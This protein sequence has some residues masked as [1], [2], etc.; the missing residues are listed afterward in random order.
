MAPQQGATYDDILRQAR[1][2]ER[3]GFYA[4]VRSEHFLTFSGDG[5]PGP[6]DAWVTLAGLAR[7]TSR[8]RL[9]TM[10]SPATF[11]LPGPL[12]VA[13]AQVDAMSGGRVSLGLGAGWADQE[14]LAYGLPFP[15][16]A[17]RFD[18]LDEQLS[19]IRGLWTTPIG[20]PFDFRGTHYELSG[21]PGLPKPVQRPH[22]PIVVG[23]SGR[24]RTPAVAARHAD[25]FNF[26]SPLPS[27]P[28]LHEAF[29]R[30]D[31][32]CEDRGRDPTTLKRSLT[33]TVVCGDDDA[34]LRRRLEAPGGAFFDIAGTPRR[35][36][37][38]IGEFRS[39]E[40]ERVYLRVNDLHDT[41]QVD[42]LGTHVVGPLS[43][44]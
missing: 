38:Q 32:A 23:G 13:V 25:E 11:R 14:H 37:E 2:A 24:R 33:V 20:Q 29:G 7:E 28:E 5:L 4:F 44:G 6:T 36:T 43:H 39:I 17:E 21:S 8:I 10:V 41:Q 35:V 16:P 3:L 12:A 15:S 18:R 34:D 40:V 1:R 42:L 27:L 22:P 9:G 31:R 30:V 19:I 26:P